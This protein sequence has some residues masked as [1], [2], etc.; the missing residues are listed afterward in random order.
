VIAL[1]GLDWGSTHVRAYAFDAHGSVT[2]RAQ[3]N[4]GALSLKTPQ[5]FDDALRNLIG[6]WATQYPVN[7]AIALIACGM[8]GAKSGW[9]EASYVPT[10][11]NT[12]SQAAALAANLTAVETS[13]GHPLF[14]IP[15]LRSD[16]P[17]VMRGEETQL[18]GCGIANGIVV[19]PGTHCKWVQLSNHVVTSFATFYTGEMNALIRDHSSVG[20]L[21]KSAP[22]VTDSVAFELGVNYARAGAASWLHDLFVLRASVATGQRS[23][24]FVSTVLAGWLLGSEISAALSMYPD[25]RA[26]TLVAS[27]ALVPWYDAALRAYG[28]SAEALDA[29][30]VSARGLWRIAQCAHGANSSSPREIQS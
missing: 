23:E 12:Q 28:V 15:G 20:T 10:G 4:A 22:D 13:F 7:S 2:A 29:E 25:T 9:R 30:Q 21:I 6:P 16:E 26:V 1:I 18:V 8:V 27:A 3:S 24:A 14:I 5:Q 17:D 11:S 19:L